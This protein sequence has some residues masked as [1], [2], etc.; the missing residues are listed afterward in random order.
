MD[1]FKEH[2]DK[3]GVN[4]M[5]TMWLGKFGGS[6]NRKFR[7]T[8]ELVRKQE[9]DYIVKCPD[10][11]TRNKIRAELIFQPRIIMEETFVKISHRPSLDSG[12]IT[13]DIF[14]CEREGF[15]SLYQFLET[16]Y[17]YAMPELLVKHSS[18]EN[19]IL[20][21]K[22][23]DGC[24]TVIESWTLSQLY[25]SAFQWGYIEDDDLS[26]TFKYEKSDYT[27]HTVE[28]MR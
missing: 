9:S 25:I 3:L 19:V 18:F 22:L 7:W 2:N 1:E 27:N 13:I 26:M 17:E 11:I 21:I 5:D 24:G 23:Y 12:S 14:D 4:G 8:A 16:I 15:A 10:V 20:N 6:V 28:I